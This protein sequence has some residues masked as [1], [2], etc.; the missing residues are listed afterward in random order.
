MKPK[1]DRTKLLLIAFS[2]MLLSACATVPQ[3]TLDIESGRLSAGATVGTVWISPCSTGKGCR[4][5]GDASVLGEFV[6]VG[7]NG[8][9]IYGS[10]LAA[11]Q[12]IIDALDTISS[13]P[14]VERKFSQPMQN[15]LRSAGFSVSVNNDNLYAGD[16]EIIGKR[17]AVNFATTIDEKYPREPGKVRGFPLILQQKDFDLSAVAGSMNVDYL[18]VLEVY[19]FNVQREF[20]PLAI[21]LTQPYGMSLVRATLVDVKTGERIFDDWGFGEKFVE[22][23]EWRQPGDW[24]NVLAITEEALELAI[25]RVM[26][27][28]STAIGGG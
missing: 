10:V 26:E 20:G 3:S 27:S 15:L 13:A 16:L 18:A 8:L 5:S 6:P 17:T 1:A 14:I 21:P 25:D 23:G 28:F 7:A 4:K 2:F 11:H 19:R 22:T 24:S 12:E 9:L